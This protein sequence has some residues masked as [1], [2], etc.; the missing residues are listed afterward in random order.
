[1]NI[2]KKYATNFKRYGA[3]RNYALDS[4]E[5]HTIGTAQNTAESVFN[6][7]NQSNPGGIV[8][9]I[10]AA[11]EYDKVLEILPRDNIAWADGGYGNQ[12]SYTIEVCESDFMKY[13]PN[14]ANYTITNNERF[15]ADILRGY[16]N[17]VRYVALKCKEFG[18]NPTDKLPNGLYRVYSHQEANAKG[19][20]TAHVDPTHIWPKIDKNMDTFRA[21]VKAA[22][23][24]SNVNIKGIKID[25]SNVEAISKVV[26]GEAGI[27]KSYDALIA[28]AQCIKDMLDSEKFGK[29]ITDVMEKN[30]SAFGN[31][32]TTDEARQA[33]YDVFVNGEKRFTD[34]KIYQFRSFKKY[35]D[36]N[37]NM[38]AEKCADLLKKYEYL[39]KD[40]R[41]NEWGH[42]YFGEKIKSEKQYVVQAGKFESR[43]N[44]ERLV[45]ELKKAGFEAII[46][47]E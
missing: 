21:D 32:E 12:H 41:N 15:L 43:E 23:G 17:A 31:K 27:I 8:H 26:Y 2:I 11:D 1:M 3:K 4:I 9:A 24:L 33:V 28:V 14:S 46:K 42:L 19:L 47:E 34:A 40:A 45:A 5:I 18:F 25:N 6:A 35:S 39:G 13:L 20:A 7:M 30:F 38:D 10:V 16:D 44:A 37:G 36:G 29:T 22:M